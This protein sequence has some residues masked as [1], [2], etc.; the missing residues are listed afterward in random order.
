MGDRS[1]KVR[2]TRFAPSPTGHLHVGGARTALF[3]WALARA[4]GGTFILRVEDTDRRRSSDAAA[5]AILEDL[6]WLAIRWD[7]GPEYEGGGGGDSGPYQQSQR[8][9]LYRR[10]AEQLI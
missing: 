5:R 8:V 1:S 2:R 10:Y 4:E 3:C 7:E 6:K 9:D